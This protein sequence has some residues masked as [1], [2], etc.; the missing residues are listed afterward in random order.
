MLVGIVEGLLLLGTGQLQRIRGIVSDEGNAQWKANPGPAF[1]LFASSVSIF[2]LASVSLER[3]L[4]VLCPFCHGTTKTRFYI[5][6]VTVT[7]VIGLF[8]ARSLLG[9]L[10]LPA[11]SKERTFQRHGSVFPFY[12]IVCDLWQLPENT[13]STC[14]R[15]HPNSTF[16]VVNLLNAIYDFQE[17]FLLQL[18]Y[19][20]VLSMPAAVVY[21]TRELCHGCF[22]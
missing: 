12:F 3:A 11:K 4:A 21:I 13:Q 1:Q 16:L 17:Q 18:L 2:F 20:S 6:I 8:Y 10:L 19:P 5:Y 14:D 15:L 7:W 22:P 9:S